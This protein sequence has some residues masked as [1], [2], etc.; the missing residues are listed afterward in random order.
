MALARSQV[1]VLALA[2]LAALWVVGLIFGLSFLYA[3]KVNALV[4]QT[5]KVVEH[6][7][8]PPTHDWASMD[9]TCA[10]EFPCSG[11]AAG[12][13]VFLYQEGRR[14]YYLYFDRAEELVSVQ[15]VT[16]R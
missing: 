6:E 16:R 9:F 13:P 1:A 8:G 7:L 2:S 10:A 3:R 15:A 4:G 11:Q 14:G 12:G 5:R